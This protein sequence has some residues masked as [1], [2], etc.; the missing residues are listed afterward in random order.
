MRR[1]RVPHRRQGWERFVNPDRSSVKGSGSLA[2]CFLVKRSQYV[3]CLH[4]FTKLSTGRKGIVTLGPPRVASLRPDSVL[5]EQSLPLSA[6]EVNVRSLR[7]I[8]L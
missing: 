2:P 5:Y 8:S 4:T 7:R 3:P 1:Q 6:R